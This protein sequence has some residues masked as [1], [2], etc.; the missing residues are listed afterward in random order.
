MIDAIRTV[1]GTLM[2][3]FA[4]FAYRMSMTQVTSYIQCIV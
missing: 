3:D 2:T 1:D 4:I